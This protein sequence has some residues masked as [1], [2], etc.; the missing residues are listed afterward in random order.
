[1][2]QLITIYHLI[3]LSALWIGAQTYLPGHSYFDAHQYIQYIAG[4]LPVIISAP[5]GGSITPDNIPDRTYGTMVT[6][7][8][9]METAMAIFHAFKDLTGHYPHVIIC[10][11]KRTKLDANRPIDEAAQGNTTAEQAWRDYHNFIEIAKDSVTHKTGQGFYIDLHGHGHSKK[12]LELGYLLSASELRSPSLNRPDL[13]NKS[14]FRHL[15]GI[16]RDDFDL[17]LRGAHSLGTLFDVE[18]YPAVPSLHD[19]APQV[20]D[21][22]FSG[23]YS[24]QRHGSLQGG[25][26]DGVQLEAWFKGVRDTDSNRRRFADALVH[27]FN[28]FVREQL[29]WKSITG[30]DSSIRFISPIFTA[31]V[32]P[33]PATSFIEVFYNL[34]ENA[35]QPKLYL[36]DINGRLL[37]TTAH[38]PSIPGENRYKLNIAGLSAGLYLLRL[39]L[40]GYT[41]VIFK[42]THLH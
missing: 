12:R 3:L 7:S 42:I 8:Y 25:V 20:N 28:R 14:S 15:S 30:L 2:R 11:L 13:M 18:G 10:R 38:L 40:P 23:G 26:I 39:T 37:R 41:P 16:A 22:Y 4:D 6:D 21:P 19:T 36:Y 33:N 17:L 34:P 32:S 31:R 29:G 5:H 35:A 27:V 1:M 9:T 24:T